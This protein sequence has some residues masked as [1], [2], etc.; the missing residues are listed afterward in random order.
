M[1]LFI[2]SILTCP[3]STKTHIVLLSIHH[4]CGSQ[5]LR[6]DVITWMLYTLLQN[7]CL[8]QRYVSHEGISAIWLIIS[9]LTTIQSVHMGKFSPFQGT[10]I[11]EYPVLQKSETNQKQDVTP[12]C[13]VW[14]FHW[15]YF[16]L[17][18]SERLLSDTKMFLGNKPT[19][20]FYY[21]ALFIGTVCC[22]GS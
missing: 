2:L 6:E 13:I 17:P 14:K 9:I 12:C 11:L 10:H 19:C 4:S 8:S 16:L 5:E 1:Q 18:E 20:L 7:F 15:S 22:N 3:I 21:K